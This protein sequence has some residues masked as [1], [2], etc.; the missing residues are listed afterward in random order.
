MPAR[1]DSDQTRETWLLIRNNGTWI[2]VFKSHCEFDRVVG[3]VDQI[4]FGAQVSF[5]G[6]DRRVTEQ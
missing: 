1:S 3:R 4:L 6:L 2:S 5:R